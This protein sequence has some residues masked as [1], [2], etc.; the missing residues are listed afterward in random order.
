MLRVQVDVVETLFSAVVRSSPSPASPAS[1]RLGLARFLIRTLDR[2]RH[3]GSL[4]QSPASPEDL[5]VSDAHLRVA[6]R[7]RHHRVLRARFA[8]HHELSGLLQLPQSERG[9]PL[10]LLRLARGS[11]LSL[12]WLEVVF[13][14]PLFPATALLSVDSDS[15][16]SELTCGL[17]KFCSFLL[18]EPRLRPRLRLPLI[19]FPKLSLIFVCSSSVIVT[20][21]ATR[22]PTLS[23][24]R[25]GTTCSSGL[26][27]SGH[28]L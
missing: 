8:R 17:L 20:H 22:R 16:L 7:L 23:V 10:R 3:F 25:I 28:Y 6:R 1:L 19:M 18:V 13:L 27:S 24:A 4:A 15:P 11:V 9:G 14:D 2:L 26:S 12:R 5:R 21:C